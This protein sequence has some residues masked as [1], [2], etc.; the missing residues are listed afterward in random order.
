MVVLLEAEHQHLFPGISFS[1]LEGINDHTAHDTAH[2]LYTCIYIYMRHV[3]F[4]LY[5]AGQLVLCHGTKVVVPQGEA[6]GVRHGG[7]RLGFVEAHGV[8]QRVG[9]DMTWKPK[10]ITNHDESKRGRDKKKKERE[11]E[12]GRER[13]EGGPEKNCGKR[14]KRGKREVIRGR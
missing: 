10:K 11:R 13:G 8:V 1:L 2:N 5:L 14:E 12:G 7:P 3:Y 6:L 4:V 9:V